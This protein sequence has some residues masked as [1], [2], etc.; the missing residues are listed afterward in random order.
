MDEQ[1]AAAAHVAHPLDE[2]EQQR[3]GRGPGCL[4]SLGQEPRQG[5]SDRE[6]QRDEHEDPADPEGRGDERTAGGGSDDPRHGKGRLLQRD[7]VADVARVEHVPDDRLADGAEEGE[8]RPLDQ[9]LH[10]E[11]PVLDEVSEHEDREHHDLERVEELNRREQPALG[12]AVG[13]D[14]RPE[15][16]DEHRDAEREEETAERR[17]RV[18]QLEREEAAH[19]EQRHDAEELEECDE[20]E[21]AVRRQLQRGEGAVVSQGHASGP[22]RARIARRYSLAAHA[23]PR[24]GPSSH[25]P[26]ALAAMARPAVRG[27]QPEAPKQRTEGRD[28]EDP[29]Q[30]CDRDQQAGAR[31]SA[32]A[33]NN[34]A[35]EPPPPMIAVEVPR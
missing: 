8:G 2:V 10:E 11:H 19:D 17:I 15:H 6:H 25:G 5:G 16:R 34:T 21:Q 13:V 14:P 1:R 7:P 35:A 26:D 33:L 18:G 4:R 31:P 28:H 20:P 3:A 30:P 24:A 12:D 27:E 22:R 29:A 23:A 9:R 32:T